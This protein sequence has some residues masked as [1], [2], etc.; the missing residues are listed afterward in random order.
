MTMFRSNDMEK[1]EYIG[2]SKDGTINEF[3]LFANVVSRTNDTVTYYRCMKFGKVP[4][5]NRK[6]VTVTIETFEYYYQPLT[7]EMYEKCLAVAREKYGLFL[8]ERKGE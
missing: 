1:F 6:P 3:T 8:E 4:C 2:I 7:E 5:F